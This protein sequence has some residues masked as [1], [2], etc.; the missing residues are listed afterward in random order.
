MRARSVLI[1]LGLLVLLFL[2]AGFF[3][4]GGDPAGESGKDFPPHAIQQ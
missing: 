1:T 3:R 2:V 4:M